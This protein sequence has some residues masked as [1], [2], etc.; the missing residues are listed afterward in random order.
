MS[1][2]NFS[3]GLNFEIKDSGETD[4]RLEHC[5]LIL[6]L[7]LKS[8]E[9]K[10][11]KENQFGGQQVSEV[12]PKTTSFRG[13]TSDRQFSIVRQNWTT[14]F[15]IHSGDSKKPDGD[16]HEPDSFRRCS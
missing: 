7:S 12:Y 3:F 14:T 10:N 6:M 8:K 4:R 9:R 11:S 13:K 5:W 2:P 1:E 15:V 16:E